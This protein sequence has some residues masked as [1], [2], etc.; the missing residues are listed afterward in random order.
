MD[1]DYEQQKSIIEDKSRFKLLNGVP[2]SLKTLT[3]VK[4]VIYDAIKVNEIQSNKLIIKST[5]YGDIKT[6]NLNIFEACDF[7]SFHGC[8]NTLTGSVTEEI[9]NRLSEYL[10]INFN[11]I[12]SHYI[13]KNKY[14][15]INISSMD[16]FIH[17]QLL[18]YKSPILDER[19][20]YY[21]QKARIL[22]EDIENHK[23]RN[24]VTKKKDICTHNYSDEF[25]DMKYDRCRLLITICE[26][27]NIC[28]NIYGDILQTIYVHSISNNSEHP[29]IEWKNSIGATE[30]NNNI[31]FRCPSS[32]LKLLEAILSQ[33]I[34]SG[35]TAYECY[36]VPIAK[37]PEGKIDKEN[38][39]PIMFTHPKTSSNYEGDIIAKQITS[40]IE[41]LMDCD[42]TIK[43]GD[44][45]IIMKKSNG[46]HT[47][48]KINERLS[49]LYKDLGFTDNIKIFETRGDGSHNK[50][51]W[52]D[53]MD[54]NG[55]C[56][57]T[58][59]ISIHGDK[60]KGHRAVYFIG[61]SEKS[62][63]LDVHLHKPEEITEVSAL[64]VG[65]TRS[66]QYLFVGFNHNL[67]SRYIKDIVRADNSKKIG[68]IKKDKL[69]ICS[70]ETPENIPNEFYKK[71]IDAL[72]KPWTSITNNESYF[73]KPATI[74]G[75]IPAYIEKPVYMPIDPE[76]SIS[77]IH[78][79]FTE[80]E[81]IIKI[82][83]KMVY[84]TGVRCHFDVDKDYL[85][86][87]LG[88]FGEI[89][90]VREHLY[91][92]CGEYDYTE[93][94]FK[95]ELIGNL[96]FI[97]TIINKKVHYTNNNELMNIVFDS[98]LNT[99]TL[100]SINNRSHFETIIEENKGNIKLIQEVQ[101]IIDKRLS[102][103]LP[104]SFNN[105]EIISSINKF[106][107]YIKSDRLLIKDIWNLALIQSI[108]TDDIYKPCLNTWLNN[109]PE[110]D[111]KDMLINIRY[112]QG[113]LKIDDI[114]DVD[115]QCRHHTTRCIT[116][117]KLISELGKEGCKDLSFG[118]IGRSD[119][120]DIKKKT[121]Y[122]IKVP[123]SDTFNNGWIS[124]V[125]GYLITDIKSSNLK[126]ENFKKWKKAG[127][128]DITNGKVW[129]FKYDFNHM[130]KRSILKHI[131]KV[132]NVHEKVIRY[133]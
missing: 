127:I 112:I 70:W 28:M 125:T 31:C 78:D 20:D 79:E 88:N 27:F 110:I 51:D 102:I 30:F 95:Q 57:K 80:P 3:L 103:I 84:N 34:Y 10:N 72:M 15:S 41:C 29:M 108:I 118:L 8:I 101:Q 73:P 119:M 76:I 96:T 86:P 126:P 68:L 7:K 4:Q 66:T 59:M 1:Y 113:F 83:K 5:K 121:L 97:D 90:F 130:D 19:G 123:M 54:S 98:K 93:E 60:G 114:D 63:P 91:N 48:H 23:L 32:H 128:I 61:L 122:D 24:I 81:N 105:K 92:L 14:I 94:L 33:K 50:I 99:N 53:V 11:K 77:K 58:I 107:S 47:F 35:Q 36:N 16:G 18:S 12:S 117:K 46:N 55:E 82:K 87:I 124:Q 115:F 109:P 2:G 43:P 75:D 42:K 64:N 49:E 116:D 74:L 132:H 37:S 9:K 133:F 111:I 21:D 13:Y 39:T 45:C 44:I 52:E 6:Y 22:L 65:M 62:L 17:T 69:A 38:T 89:L 71:N 104:S 56:S 40:S 67:P 100:H 120:I 131:L 106:V 26:S 25:Q 129:R 85:Q